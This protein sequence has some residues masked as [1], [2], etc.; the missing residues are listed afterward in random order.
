MRL[1]DFVPP[2]F[3]LA[4]K[5]DQIKYGDII[6]DGVYR[7][8]PDMYDKRIQSTPEILE[9]DE[10]FMAN[11]MEILQ[12]FYSLFES[13]YRYNK[14]LVRFLNDLED[15][16]FIQQTLEVRPI[17]FPFPACLTVFR[18]SGRDGQL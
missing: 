14:D 17:L 6:L 11:H 1:A 13:I 2:E 8:A 10:D 18:M 7:N 9:R 16:A 12:R 15:G 5:E 4:T 3:R